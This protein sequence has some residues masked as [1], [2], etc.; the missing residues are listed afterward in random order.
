MMLGR[1]FGAAIASSLACPAAII[2]PDDGRFPSTLCDALLGYHNDEWIPNTLA[3]SF[4]KW[5]DS[6]TFPFSA[7]WAMEL[8]GVEQLLTLN[9]IDAHHSTVRSHVD[10][11]AAMHLFSTNFGELGSDCNIQCMQR[12]ASS[13]LRRVGPRVTVALLGIRTTAG[14][15]LDALPPSRSELIASFGRPH[16]PSGSGV[17]SVGARALSKHCHRGAA[18]WWGVSTGSEAEKNAHAHQLC[19]DVLDNAVWTNI[20]AIVGDVTIAEFRVAEGYGARW[21]VGSPNNPNSHS[22]S[23]DSN[24]I[25]T[26]ETGRASPS[27][28]K[29]QTNFR[30]FLEPHSLTGHE[31]GWKH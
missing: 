2:S 29:Q 26:C 7:E 3:E 28:V 20:H 19:C 18:G 8:E 14:C 4:V 5:A 10:L 1:L 13:L 30:G 15:I 17:L 27:N 31:H 24:S 12:A 23:A 11:I 16:R 21:T 9:D 25:A 6:G 22:E